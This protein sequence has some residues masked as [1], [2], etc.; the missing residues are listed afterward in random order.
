MLLSTDSSA[1]SAASNVRETQNRSVQEGLLRVNCSQMTLLVS[2]RRH[3]QFTCSMQQMHKSRNAQSEHV[4][5]WLHVLRI[6]TLTDV[7]C[8]GENSSHYEGSNFHQ[9]PAGLG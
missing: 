1:Q 6:D 2:Y 4:Y 5:V 7:T 9:G 3:M 8:L